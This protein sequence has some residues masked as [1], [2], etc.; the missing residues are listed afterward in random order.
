[1]ILA[2]GRGERMRPLT[3]ATPKPLLPVGGKPLIVHQIEALARAGFDSIAINVAWLGERIVDALGDGARWG[4]RIAWSREAEPLEVAGGIAHALPL[5]RPGPILI[6][7]GDVW[8]HYDYRTLAARI[9]VMESPDARTRAH[10]VMVPNPAWHANGDFALDGERIDLDG[11]ARC[12]Y[13]NIGIYDS[14]LFAGLVRESK[15]PLLPYLRDWIGRGLV[16][17]ERYDG[18][19]VNAGTP[20]DLD[21]LDARLSAAARTDAAMPPDAETRPS[22]EH[23]GH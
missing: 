20:A 11:A 3:D 14:A 15:A 6:V 13:G 21:A 19:W 23:D 12:T 7:S 10:L 4:V 16:S 17:G 2:A 18:P 8:T 9:A 22:A 1:M 5:M